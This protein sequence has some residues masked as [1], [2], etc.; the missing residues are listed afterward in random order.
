MQQ[1]ERTLWFGASCLW[2]RFDSTQTFGRLDCERFDAAINGSRVDDGGLR[3][4]PGLLGWQQYRYRALIVPAG[5]T[6]YPPDRRLWAS[7]IASARLHWTTHVHRLDGRI[8]RRAC[9]FLTLFPS[10]SVSVLP[11]VSGLAG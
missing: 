8:A 3:R 7:R 2:C 11:S 5:A 10:P 9:A 4:P 6:T 1:T